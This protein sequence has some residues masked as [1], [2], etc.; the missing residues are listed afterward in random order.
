MERLPG[1]PILLGDPPE[2]MT[3][4][5]IFLQLLPDMGR[6]LLGNW[7][8]LL[9]E[10]QVRLHEL[11]TEAFLRRLEADG[12]PRSRLSVEAAVRRFAAEVEEHNLDGL[13]PAVDWLNDHRPKA[14]D[15]GSICH[16]DFFPN[17]VFAQE[18]SVV[19]VIDWSDVIIG[20]AELDVGIVKAGIETLPGPLGP[21]GVALQR[22]VSKRY[23][24]AYRKLRALDTGALDYSQAF[25]CVLTL[26]SVATRRLAIAEAETPEPGPNPYDHPLAEARLTSR[27][28][29]LTG[30]RA[31]IP[32]SRK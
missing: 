11:D 14:T 19:G 25:R 7:P 30:V 15:G 5:T 16:G 23:V 20:P 17:Q 27:L 24:T 9:A 21:L 6:V 3:G 29:E 12:V 28:C 4:R 8:R 10:V 22:F 31:T 26:L 2:E 13:R 1:G 18:G 32:P